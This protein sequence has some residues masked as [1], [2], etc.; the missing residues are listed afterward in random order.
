MKDP[1]SRLVKI[2]SLASF[3][4]ALFLYG[5][6][7]DVSLGLRVKIPNEALVI[8]GQISTNRIIIKEV[9][10]TNVRLGE[11]CK[12][13]VWVSCRSYYNGIR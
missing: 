2:R 4:M 5:F 8:D 6:I 10:V 7:L 11:G 9:R 13:G 12:I 1:I 3:F